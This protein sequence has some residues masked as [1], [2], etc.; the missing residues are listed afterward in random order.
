MLGKG[1]CYIGHVTVYARFLYI[2]NIIER[3]RH[4]TASFKCAQKRFFLYFSFISLRNCLDQSP[5]L[6]RLKIPGIDSEESFPSGWE[7]IPGLLKRFT[8]TGSAFS[9]LFAF[10]IGV[11][12]QSANGELAT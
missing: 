7:S 5:Y 11:T 2:Q 4:K 1:E 12:G 8:N 10:V 9:W 6:K 3:N